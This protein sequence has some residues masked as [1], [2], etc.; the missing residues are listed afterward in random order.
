LE[1]CRS[2]RDVNRVL[3]SLS[4]LGFVEGRE[5]RV[6]GAAQEVFDEMAS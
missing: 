6:P 5:L 4:F 1:F 2:G 3:T